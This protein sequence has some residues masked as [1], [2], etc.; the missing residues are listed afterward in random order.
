MKQQLSMICIVTT[1]IKKYGNINQKKVMLPPQDLVVRVLSMEMKSTILEA[2]LTDK[3]STS[4][5]C[6]SIFLF[7]YFRFDFKN[8]YWNLIKANKDI[9]PR[10]DM[11]LV[12]NNGKLYIFGGADSS[13]RYN[14]LH[15]F[16][17]STSQWTRLQTHG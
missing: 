2:T 13:S 6:I 16:E 7:I 9:Q 10:V 1:L 8:K 3:G 11:T 15:Q 12:I 17:I 4:M 5:I 14:D